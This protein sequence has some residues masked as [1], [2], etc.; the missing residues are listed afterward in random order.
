M[1][2]S[3]TFSQLLANVTSLSTQLAALSGLPASAAGIQQNA[4]GLING[5]VVT[6]REIQA[7]VLDYTT[8]TIPAL[9]N[10]LTALQQSQDPA[11]VASAKTTVSNASQAA[12]TLSGS[13]TGKINGVMDTKTQIISLSNQLSV[14]AQGLNSQIVALRSQAQD[15]QNQADYYTTRKYYFLALGPLGLVGL[16]IAIG[17]IVSWSNK[18]SD[19]SSQVNA[20]NVQANALQLLVTNVEGIVAAFSNTVNQI[21]NIKNGVDFLSSDIST[22]IN[23]LDNSSTQNAILFLTAAVHEVE[24][25]KSDAS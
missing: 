7:A 1:T 24:T 16:G 20:A 3:G 18:A 13:I 9:N 6:L 5:D 12:A 10:V 21:S 22:I 11:T 17:M 15:A 8:P 25:L 2:V 4:I 14:V 19:Y 23:D